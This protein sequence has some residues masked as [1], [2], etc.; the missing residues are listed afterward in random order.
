MHYQNFSQVLVYAN[1]VISRKSKVI[2]KVV[3]DLVCKLN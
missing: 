2:G 3:E 1:R